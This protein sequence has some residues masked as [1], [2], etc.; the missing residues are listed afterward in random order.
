MYKE[1]FEKENAILREQYYGKNPITDHIDKEFDEC[2]KLAKQMT[3]LKVDPRIECGINKHLNNIKEDLKELFNFK[4]VRIN[5]IQM[6]QINAF[7]FGLSVDQAYHS[8]TTIKEKGKYG[9][10]YKDSA[11]RACMV[12]LSYE[13]MRLKEMT[14]RI[15]TAILL[16]EIGH[17]FFMEESLSYYIVQTKMLLNLALFPQF[18]LLTTNKGKSI[19]IK[20]S[21]FFNKLFKINPLYISIRNMISRV[22]S[23]FNFLIFIGYNIPNIIITNNPITYVMNKIYKYVTN[24]TEIFDTNNTYKNEMFADNFATAYGYGPEIIKL[25]RIFSNSFGMELFDKMAENELTKIMLSII[26]DFSKLMKSIDPTNP[27]AG[28]VSRALDQINYIEKNLNNIK[29]EQAKQLKRDLAL[30]KTEIMNFKKQVYSPEVTTLRNEYQKN[31]FDNGGEVAYKFRKNMASD[32]NG[33][34]KSLL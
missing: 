29:G 17:N 33:N 20:I 21:D 11:K 12:T 25:S 14:G 24:P 27:R 34:W 6:G 28:E 30:A 4:D 19:T 7:T 23:I 1:D 22:I 18:A 26:L 5:I 9:I 15:M 16:H 31:E 2:I 3:L 8:Q 32:D 10:R 13:I